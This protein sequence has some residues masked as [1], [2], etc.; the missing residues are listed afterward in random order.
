MQPKRG[1]RL[2]EVSDKR[3]LTELITYSLLNFVFHYNVLTD[4]DSRMYHISYSSLKK[5]KML[6]LGG[7]LKSQR[8][9]RSRYL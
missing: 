6:M 8:Q 2:I 7:T 4:V 9:K 3:D 5:V 1:A